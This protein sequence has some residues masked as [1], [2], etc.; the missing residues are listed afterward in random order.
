[1]TPV[2][3]TAPRMTPAGRS[4]SRRCPC[5]ASPA[6]STAAPAW[7]QSRPRHP[8]RP[9]AILH[10]LPEEDQAGPRL[11]QG[12]AAEPEVDGEEGVPCGGHDSGP[13][14]RPGRAVRQAYSDLVTRRFAG[15]SQKLRSSSDAYLAARLAGPVNRDH[16]SILASRPARF[17]RRPRH[18]A[19]AARYWAWTPSNH[20]F[21]TFRHQALSAA[22][23]LA[24]W[25]RRFAS[26]RTACWAAGHRR[27]GRRRAARRSGS[28]G[29][30][31]WS[32]LAAEQV[33]CAAPVGLGEQ[34]CLDR[35]GGAVERGTGQ[36]GPAV[37]RRRRR[38]HRRRRRR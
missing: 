24:R 17:S 6:R 21:S 31:R 27:R 29:R 22:D 9:S 34:R 8:G 19:S 12:D 4:L 2:R 36:I 14:Y 38:R 7:I 16:G 35:R 25:S 10:I 13:A 37:S 15:S 23:C 30:C 3:V 32:R 20:S 26:A 33:R 28:E 5:P 1:M 18:W 11:L